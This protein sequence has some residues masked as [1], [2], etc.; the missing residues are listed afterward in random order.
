[1]TARATWTRHGVLGPPTRLER[2]ALLLALALAAALMW[3]L[4][5]YVTDDTYIHLQYARHLAHGV[6]PVFNRG[7]RV[8]GCTSPLW[9]ALLADGMA[10]GADGLQLAHV[11]GMLATLA[12]VAFFWQLLRRNLHTPALIAAGTLAWASHAWMI[13]W[14]TSGMET[15]LAVALTLAGFVAFTEGQQ[16]G[17]RPVRTGALWALAA[18][19]RPEAALLLV[20][21][22]IFLVVDADSRAGALRMAYG[23][24]PPLVIYGG[25]L[26]FAWL[27][28]HAVL[29]QTLSA[30][31][32]GMALAGRLESF[33]RELKIIGATDGLLLLVLAAALVAQL[34][35]RRVT[36][37]RAQSLVPW[38]WVLCV[39]AL[40]LARGVP[41]LSRYLVPLL[42]VL[43]WLA[44]EW[45][46][47][48]LRGDDP[49]PARARR[50]AWA[51]AIMAALVIAQNVVVW[52]RTVLPQVTSFSPALQS[53]LVRWG[54][55][56]GAHAPRDASIAT[57]D[58]G[59]I[60][61]FS[62]R[63]V[64]DLGGL[65]TPQMVPYLERE[66]PEQA[67]AQF[68]FASFVHPAYVVDR[69]EQAYDLLR[70][71]PYAACLDTLGTAA[72]PNL[73]VAR[74]GTR[75]YS[76]YQVDWDEYQRLKGAQR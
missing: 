24:I 61:Y 69:A 44:W 22:G 11:L 37:L 70:R 29:P 33:V 32:A 3:P 43:A 2:V 36:R 19:T 52:R 4:R 30:K 48:V 40:Y 72:V 10:L 53:S 63:R 46:E 42:A 23:V 47:R 34:R 41:V 64:V 1:M 55:W 60:G 62:D 20:L 15:A 76:F 26:L 18:L 65:V 56:F 31:A 74:P 5:G 68:R 39:P 66:E 9:V 73:G 57:P 17:A 13:R 67:I 35:A 6:G 49:S 50:L 75:V 54:R 71:S 25:W 14:S 7:E 45:L 21:W 51:G 8:Y 16:W 38:A 28:F 12:S 27:Y 58:I 59:A